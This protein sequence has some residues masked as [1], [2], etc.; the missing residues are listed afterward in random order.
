MDFIKQNWSI[1][2]WFLGI[3]FFALTWYFSVSAR[4]G[5]VETR[6]DNHDVEL[7]I[8]EKRL[9]KKHDLLLEIKFNLRKF[10][11][12]SGESYTEGG[13]F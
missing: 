12:A 8:I 13:G 1:I 3:I 11:E 9:D 6:L 4:M 7:H 2:K 5:V 10:M